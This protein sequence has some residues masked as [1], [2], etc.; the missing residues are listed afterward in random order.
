MDDILKK[1]AF[2]NWYK[3]DTLQ[4]LNRIVNLGIFPGSDYKSVEK[5]HKFLQESWDKTLQSIKDNPWYIAEKK[6]MEEL[7]METIMK[8][9]TGEYDPNYKVKMEDVFRKVFKEDKK[10]GNSK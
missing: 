6:A 1:E 7:D 5:L 9:G 2:D 8:D 3:L 4:E 10:N